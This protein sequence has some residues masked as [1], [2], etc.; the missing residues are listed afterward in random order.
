M[1]IDLG[2]LAITLMATRYDIHK[3]APDVIALPDNYFA[4][5]RSPEEVSLVTPQG[6]TVTAQESQ[7]GWACFRVEGPLD[8]SLVGI[9]A[10]ISQCLAEAKLS[11]FVI[12]SY[13]TDYILVREKDANAAR[14]TLINCGAKLLQE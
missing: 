4:V 8:F 2:D 10:R 6:V 12:S 11:I 7:L 14:Q 5:L 13:L 3:L 1:A 9:L